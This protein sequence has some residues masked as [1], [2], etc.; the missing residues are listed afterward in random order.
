MCAVGNGGANVIYGVVYVVLIVEI[1]VICY[2][3]A[4][5]VYGEICRI[6]ERC[7]PRAR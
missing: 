4:C 3:C 6:F 7:W 1:G 2:C 5:V